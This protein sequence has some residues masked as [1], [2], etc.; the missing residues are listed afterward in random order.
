MR[1]KLNKIFQQVDQEQR[2]VISIFYRIILV[3]YGTFLFFFEDNNLKWY[4][5][6]ILNICFLIFYFFLIVDRRKKTLSFL[7]LLNDYLYIGFI[8][9][10]VGKLD[11]FLWAFILIPILNAGN[12]SGP[13]KSILLYIYP[14]VLIFIIN[15]SVDYYYLIP[16]FFF[17]VIN[18]FESYRNKYQALYN[19]LNDKIDDFLVQKDSFS[20]LYKIYDEI[21][22][23]FNSKKIFHKNVDEIYCFEKKG[24]TLNIIN[25]SKFVLDFEFQTLSKTNKKKEDIILDKN[26]PITINGNLYEE[27]ILYRCKVRSTIYY[28]FLMTNKSQE[29]GSFTIPLDKNYGVILYPFFSRLSYAIKSLR[30]QYYEIKKG[31]ESMTEKVT[32]V[33]NAI[34]SMHFVR[35]KLSPLKS[36]LA[37]VED[38]NS[39]GEDKRKKIKPFIEK[40]REKLSSSIEEILERADNIL[41]KSNNPFNVTENSNYSAAKLFSIVRG[42]WNYYLDEEIFRIQ[43][44]DIDSIGDKELSFNEAGIE[45]VSVNWINNMKKYKTDDDYGLL[46]RQE[47]DYY[48]VCFY[49]SINVIKDKE[50]EFISLF[51]SSD[52]MAILKRKTHGLVEIKDFLDQM[53]MEYKLF[54]DGNKLNLSLKIKRNKGL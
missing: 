11:L 33:N 22:P 29:N 28:Y 21:I 40:E 53:N 54:I 4:Y 15:K 13:K 23:I 31:Y 37:M 10:F 39:S 18:G 1:G 12:H 6:L 52:R 41:E 51:N 30:D 35:N 42:V 47:E 44:I 38:F 7:R 19:D 2:V 43:I 24:N 50:P 14:I 49:N 48:E 27:N 46:F 25:G 9:Y 5:F 16:F 36:Y 32:Y 34:N 20:N 45:L 3:L 17:Y 26:V 8:V